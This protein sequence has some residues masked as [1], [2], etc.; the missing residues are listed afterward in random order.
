MS[1]PQ[2]GDSSRYA[3]S[4]KDELITDQQIEAEGGPRRRT[5]Q[6]WR[7]ARFGPPWI[8]LGKL[9]RYRRSDYQEWLARNSV[10]PKAE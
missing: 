2:S 10:G 4:T 8:K 3:P 1:A 9:V 7:S 5:L 6:N